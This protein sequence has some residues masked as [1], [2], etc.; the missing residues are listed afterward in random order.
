MKNIKNSYLIPF[1]C[2]AVF[3]N[4]CD[5]DLLET[6]PYGESTSANFWRNA[7]D[8][9]AAANAMYTPLR[10]EAAFGHSENVFDNCS[11][12]LYRA[13]DHGYEEAMENFTLTPSNNGVRAGWKNKYEMITRANAVLINVPD[14]EMD[15]TLKNRILGEAHFIRA[16]GYWRFSLI[17]GGVPLITEENVKESNF[18]V[19]KS[20][21]AEVQALVES[22][23]IEAVNLLP[24]MHADSDLGRPNKGT[25]NGLLAKLY[26]YQEKFNE[27]ITA[28]TN[29]VNGP[30]P[31]AANFRDNFTPST[32]N[33]PEMLFA[34]QGSAN[35]ADVPQYYIAP[36]PWGGWD[37]HNPTQDIVDEFEPGDPRL[38]YSIWQPGD[39]VDRGANG[40]SEFTADLTATGF[41]QNKYATFTADGNLDQNQNVPI[42]R[43]ADVYLIVAEAKIRL[44]GNGAGDT[45]INAV[46]DRVGMPP[47]A[48][49]GM[50]ELIHER[51]VELFGENQRHQDLMRWDKAGIVDIVQIYGE[52][53]GQFDPPRVFIKPKHYY[54]PIPQREIDLSNGVL[55]QNEGYASEN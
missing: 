36:R 29:V 4:G 18:N 12:D 2:L 30:Y 13:G 39:M 41:G 47:V 35:W 6:T 21:L 42:L 9:I 31:L 20:T 38:G 3:F 15:A 48:N 28:G 32:E 53:R 37:F 45:E 50:P 26:L 51:R 46:R 55:K 16:F 7:D 43:A 8:A 49:A 40:I 5:G 54:F 23:L 19:P 11:D 14:I 1:I 24:E 17:Y 22:D 34:A 10:E 27:A 25:A 52:D 33:N 44:S